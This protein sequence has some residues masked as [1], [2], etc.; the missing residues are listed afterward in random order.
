M[1]R[2]TTTLSRTGSHLHYLCLFVIC[3]PPSS[4]PNFQPFAT[5][6]TEFRDLIECVGT[7]S[8]IIVVGDV[9]V[10][11]GDDSDPLARAL[12]DVLSDA[13]LRQN[14]TDAARNLGIVLD[15][16]VT[17]SSPS[18]VAGVS[19][20]HLVT[21]HFAVLCDLAT[22]KPRPPRKTIAYRRYDSSSFTTDFDEC[23]LITQPL[24][25]VCGLYD[26][27]CFELSF[28]AVSVRPTSLSLSF[29]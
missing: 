7:K 21:D 27:H 4:S 6:L 11:Y 3:R 2:S 14:V 20:D 13:N 1:P 24:H 28:V 25:D 23:K 29:L 9:N 10:R 16:V 8:G 19:V 12:H 15:L 18:L 22:T 5:F 17:A 26:Q